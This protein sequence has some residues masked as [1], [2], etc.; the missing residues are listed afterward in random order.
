MTEHLV[1]SVVILACS[2]VQSVFGIG[3]LL[4]GTPLLLLLGYPFE[5]ALLYLLPCSMTVN[6][7]QVIN[8]RQ[9]IG[10]F[11]RHIFIYTL[12]F[13]MLGLFLVLQFNTRFEIKPLIGGMLL[14]TG[15]IRIFPKATQW[16]NQTLSRGLKP[17]L[18]MMGLIH[19]ITNMGGGLLAAIVNTLFNDK[20]TIRTNIAFGYLLM[21]ASQLTIL[22][23]VKKPISTVE[24]A[25]LPL[26][27]LMTYFLVGNRIFKMSNQIAYQYIMTFLIMLFGMNLLFL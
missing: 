16:L 8:N 5:T 17:S 2:L 23:L 11:A 6:L 20:K 9:E 25:V 15:L 1:L 27:S 24:G 21:A 18:A 12:P 7:L 22:V 4:F 14:F 19:G 13:L 10:P 3:L 26:I